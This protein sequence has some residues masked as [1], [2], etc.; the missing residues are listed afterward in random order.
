VVVLI[1]AYSLPSKHAAGLTGA[2]RFVLF[3]FHVLG[4]F[5]FTACVRLVTDRRIR[6][7][8]FGKD[9]LLGHASRAPGR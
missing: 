8:A 9:F 4:E 5:L 7:I 2:R 6:C 1:V 3:A